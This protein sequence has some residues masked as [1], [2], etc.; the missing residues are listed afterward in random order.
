MSI[1]K[2]TSNGESLIIDRIKKLDSE[3]TAIREEK[4]IAYTASGDTWHDNPGFNSLEQAEHRKAK[5][6]VELKDL[7]TISYKIDITKRN[8]T[9]VDVGSIVKCV[10]ISIDDPL[11]TE[12][13][14]IWEIGGFGESDPKKNVLSYET[15]VGSA[16]MGCKPDTETEQTEIAG[17]NYIFEIV[18][19][20]NSWNECNDKR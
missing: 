15:P 4:A 14:E 8:T 2:I 3:I 13:T 17:K 7:L 5:E 16:L 12:A 19:L 20:Y 1:K 10:R 6:M 18:D 9:F 11:S